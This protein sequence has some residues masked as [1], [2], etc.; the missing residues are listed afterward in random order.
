MP[1]EYR[2][3][4]TVPKLILNASGDQFFLPDLWRFYLDDLPGE[5][6]IRYI[7]NTDHSLDRSDALESLAAFYASIVNGSARPRVKW[8]F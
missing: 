6:H 3:R 8:T 4:L 7:P 1:Y 2:D 5:N